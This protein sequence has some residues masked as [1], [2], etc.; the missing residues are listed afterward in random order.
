MPVAMSFGE[1]G[2]VIGH[3]SY[4]GSWNTEPDTPLSPER[5]RQIQ[6]HALR[7]LRRKEIRDILSDYVD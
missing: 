4:S 3:E 5:V 6:E 1:I 7:R 2:K